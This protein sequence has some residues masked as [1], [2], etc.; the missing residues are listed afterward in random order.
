MV[1]QTVTGCAC[2][3]AGSNAFP[4]R[5]LGCPGSESRS[6]CPPAKQPGAGPLASQALCLRVRTG[7]CLLPHRGPLQGPNEVGQARAHRGAQPDSMSFK[8]TSP[9]SE[10]SEGRRRFLT[11]PSSSQGLPVSV[12]LRLYHTA[13]GFLPPPSLWHFQ[14]L[15]DSH[16]EANGPLHVLCSL[17]VQAAPRGGRMA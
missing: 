14:S 5:S 11:A 2:S 8:E 1:G 17:L 13:L 16:R 3:L 9:L 6:C 12:C 7:S 10:P 4:A 15:G